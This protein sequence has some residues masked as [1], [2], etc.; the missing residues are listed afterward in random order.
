MF[1]KK[2][3]GREKKEISKGNK[4]NKTQ[5]YNVHIGNTVNNIVTTLYGDRW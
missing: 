2:E 4:T 1:T 3:G 5:R